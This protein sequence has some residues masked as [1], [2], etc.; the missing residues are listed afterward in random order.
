MPLF[1]HAWWHSKPL[2]VFGVT[3][4]VFL[5]AV[6]LGELAGWP[7]LRTPLANQIAQVTG[8]TVALEG[9]FRAQLVVRPGVAV[10][11]VTL[12]GAAGVEVP[13]LL[14]AE[15]LVV[16]WRW[17]DLWR[18]SQGAP[19]KLKR[20]E[21]DQIDAHLVRLAN[22][23]T[24]WA[25]A[26]AEAAGD[27]STKPPQIETLVLRTGTIVYRDEP[28]NINLLARIT[29][30]T[31]PGT[32]LPWRATA[33]GRYREAEVD[34]AAQAGPD[35][36]LVMPTDERAALTPLRLSGRVGSTKIDFDGETGALWAGQSMRG[37]LT[38]RGASL[39]TSGEPLGL[40]LPATPPYK[41]RGRIAREGAVWSLVTED[42]TVGSSSLTAALQYDTATEPPTLAGRVGGQ[43]LAFADLAPSIGADQ[44]P[45]ER[46][47]VLPDQRLDLPSL[48][49]MNANVRVNLAQLDFGTPSIAPMTDLKAHI[50]MAN[51]RLNL[52]DLSARVAG[53]LLTGS[54]SVQ[55][56]QRPPR[57]ETALGFAEVD[58]EQWI[59][60]L[61]KG[62]ASQPD[63]SPAYLSGTLNAKLSLV[64][65]GNSVADVLGSGNG[66]LNLELVKGQISQLVTEALGLDAAQ[67]IGMVIAGDEPLRLNCARAEAVIQNGVIKTRHA[68]L[69]NKDS[70]LH[71][72][73]G[74]SLKNEALQLRVVA[75][76]KDFSPFSLRSPL[77]VV[78]TFKQPRVTVEASGLLARAAGALLLGALAPPA[79]LLAFIDTGAQPDSEPCAPVK[80]QK[81]QKAPRAKTP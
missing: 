66:R 23:N 73:G 78:G 8:S 17:L 79:A 77:N 43:R 58:L 47:R 27:T 68:V 74:A 11:R 49:Q 65:Q 69:D 64:G 25:L 80:P 7:F 9:K 63:N 3:A 26:R 21:A 70:T 53:G 31:E 12:G 59:R 34:L 19:L 76:P 37:Q 14:Q 22:G 24:S 50:T 5:G 45:R 20:L 60:A 13:H 10:E 1:S 54:T 36:P 71:I 15:G 42:A 30:S 55:A 48:K 52:L 41:M 46:G 28:L 44:P 72:Q 56:D 81:T 6:A 32:A 38:L 75:E 4:A 33:S 67:A 62:P 35:L 61:K 51:S 16:R 40:T 39:R 18:S 2:R 29:Q 57:W